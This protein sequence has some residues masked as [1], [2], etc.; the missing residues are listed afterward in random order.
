[1]YFSEEVVDVTLSSESVANGKY[2]CREA[3]DS[4]WGQGGQ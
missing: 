1:M 3:K 2:L 4:H